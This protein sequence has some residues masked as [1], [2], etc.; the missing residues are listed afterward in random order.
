MMLRLGEGTI[1]QTIFFN[2]GELCICGISVRGGGLGG[3]N[4][5]EIFKIQ[6]RANFCP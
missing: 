3:G 2:C 1:M 5:G 6:L 4:F